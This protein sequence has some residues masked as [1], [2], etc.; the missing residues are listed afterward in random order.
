MTCHTISIKSN[1]RNDNPHDF[2]RGG[3]SVA[4][5]PRATGL[6]VSGLLG[7]IKLTSVVAA[8][9]P[10]LRVTAFPKLAVCWLSLTFTP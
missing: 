4:G 8:G 7:A 10:T 2:R 3:N 5:Y 9:S 6:V 1:Y